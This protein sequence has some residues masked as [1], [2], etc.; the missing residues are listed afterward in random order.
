MQDTPLLSY[1][2]Y[3]DGKIVIDEIT[4]EDRFGDM[5]RDSSKFHSQSVAK[6][7]I[8]YVAGHA[9]CKGY[10]DSVDSR[11]ND[12]PVLENTLYHNQKL[13][14]V[15]NMASGTQSY[16]DGPNRFSNSNRAVT[17][18]SVEDAMK[19]ELKGS[20]KSSSIYNYNNM[21]P[22]VVGSY[23]IYKL[24]DENFQQLL[25]DVFKKKVKIEGNA[26]FLKN[27]FAKKDDKSIW[28]QFYA[29]RYDYLR[30]AKT[31]LDDWQ[32]DTC[33]GQYLKT[34]HERRIN[35][36]NWGGRPGSR[37][38]MPEGYAGF[39][40]T[41]YKGMANRPVMSM[42]GYGGQT[43]TIDF[44]RGRIIAT[45]SIH[46]NMMFPKPGGYD[47]KKIVYERIKNGK[48]SS[49]SKPTPKQVV[50]SQ[51][52]IKERNAAI[53]TEKKAKQY[54][55][56]YY[57]CTE[58]SSGKSNVEACI[59][60]IVKKRERVNKLTEKS[61]EKV[62][63][64]TYGGG[65]YISESE[66]P[67]FDSLKWS[68][69]RKL[70]YRPLSGDRFYSVQ[71]SNPF[72][73]EFDLREDR[74]IKQQMQTTP[75]LSYL[76]FE[77]GKIVVDEITPKVRFGDKFSDT[78]MFH[79]MSMGKSITSYLAGHAICEG[80]IKSVDSRLDWP[81]LKNTL[82]DNQK[83]I[84]LLNMASGDKAYSQNDES[85]ESIQSRMATEFRGSK[86][87]IHQYHYTN[88]NTNLVL[89]YLLYTYG[90]DDFK[91]LFDDVFQKKV[92]IKNEVWLNKTP[93]A[94]KNEKSLGHQFF[95]TRYDYLRIAKAMLD[96]WQKDNC[97]GQY[98][99]T[100]HERRISKNGA[101]G[102]T[103]RVGLPL[104]YGGFFHTG[105][106]GME[107][108]PV[109]GM[110]GNG[111]Q[112]I[113]IDF[114]RGRIV[115]TQSV[116]D[117]MRFPDKASY[118]WEK[119]SY[120]RIKNGKPT[121]KSIT[122]K[123]A[124]PVMDPQELIL[125]NKD[126]R[127][128]DRKAKEYWDEY[129]DKIFFGGSDDGAILLSEDFE[130]L[131]E[132]DILTADRDDHWF[133]KQDSDGN[134][135][136]CNKN[137]IST[138][139]YA[140]FNLGSENW[141][142][143]S[144]SYRMKFT[145]GR[146]GELETHIRKNSNRQGEYRSVIDSVMGYTFLKYVK[147]ADRINKRIANGSRAPIRDKWA[148]IQLIASG[149]NIV[150]IVNGKVVAS[151]E[152][153][154][155]IKGAVMFAVTSKSELCI[156]DI[157]IK[158]V[159]KTE[160]TKT[161]VAKKVETSDS[162]PTVSKIIEVTHGDKLIVDIAEPH[163]LAGSNIKVSLKD[164]DAPDATRSCPKQMEL[165]LKVKDYVAQKLENATSIKLTNF[166]KTNTKII[167][168][169]IVDG[170]DLSEELVSKGYA[171]EEYGFW[172]PYFCSA[173]SATNQ[174]DQYVDTD[175]KKAIF[176]YERS[177]VLDPDGSKNQQSHF[178]LSQ[179]YSNFGNADKSLE[180]LKKSA[181]LEWIP[182]MEQLGSDYLNGNGVKKD[183]N[184]GKKWLK[185][186]FDKGSQRA[187]D[188]YCGSLPK[189]KQKTCKL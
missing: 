32:N 62:E 22:N 150:Y 78:S 53:E 37:V 159:S 118:D 180:N 61:T 168:Q 94:D 152:D 36:G 1:L 84:N 31:M 184:Q 164:I 138:S 151:T 187:E 89:S 162:D 143:Y 102:T 4:P 10:I 45:Q 91:R 99:K 80:K 81:I 134:S 100:I 160:E 3:E 166:R 39:F 67:N 109:M 75:L 146:G 44:E 136:Y 64:N 79:S 57:D 156:D 101:Q 111:G 129:Y 120:E 24:G 47:W 63:I 38:S 113:L 157:V 169:V 52:I 158:K 72:N 93:G 71:A 55:D 92:G 137:V 106:K 35:K 171:S 183:P 145:P 96:D 12:W 140:H 103:G 69:Y 189:A 65:G 108:R 7:L 30:I 26:F 77:D 34:I 14:D 29:T 110:D 126:R 177:I 127:E 122:A 139:D 6:T 21:N 18:P 8:G 70:H 155:L 154:R 125:H 82:Y 15:L 121:S 173:L 9:I 132:R 185:K 148:D 16:F 115:V 135:I 117:N 123:S 58:T 95:T 175:Q 119:I 46:D 172:K 188:I 13:I 98:L 97:V 104:S 179:M 181:S 130:N 11:L 20:K 23:L 28:T 41:N 149:N 107:N 76:L 33:A 42:D 87:S 66:S 147:G 59:D 153:D 74:Y 161:A 163:E 48:P 17:S 2:L 5:F 174:A 105:Y 186:A 90:E 60:K 73:F 40:H 25:D 85:N 54:W 141:R 133:V 112:T 128:S 49:K 142:D 88:L 170:V 178:A 131:D 19:K 86:K 83:L 124:S 182:A 165:G 176:W 56:D 51:Q 50:D 27:E 114:D 43:I 116:F 167:A 68:L 144:I